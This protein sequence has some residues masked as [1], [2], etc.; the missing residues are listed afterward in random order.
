MMRL[1]ELTSPEVAALDRDGT[2]IRER[3]YL[4]DP[5][6]VELLPGAA[7]AMRRLAVAGYALVIV[8]NQSGLAR[9]LFGEAQ[10]AAVQSRVDA[11]LAGA[12]VHLDGA[13]F[14][15]HHPEF[16]GPCDCRKPAPGLYRQAAQELG[17]DLARSVYIGDRISD[18]EIAETVGGTG[19]LVQTGYGAAEAQRVPSG[20]QVA[21]DLEAAADLVLGA[22]NS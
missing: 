1:E 15:P 18:V 16:T 11:L 6:G 2:V 7:A 21:A 13:Y 8:T 20:V 3:E 22:A 9:G 14:C 19:I 5:E 10:R 12:G 4:A 17:I